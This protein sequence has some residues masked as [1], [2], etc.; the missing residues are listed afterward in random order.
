MEPET[1]APSVHRLRGYVLALTA[2]AVAASGTLV[3]LGYDEGNIWV[4]IA[5][6]ITAAIADR[7]SVRV[8]DALELSISPVLTLFAAVLF[9]PLAGG[10]V[11]AAHSSHSVSPDGRSTGRSQK[12]IGG[13]SCEP[14]LPQSGGGCCRC[15]FCGG[16][17]EGAPPPL[18]RGLGTSEPPPEP[19]EPPLIP[20]PPMTANLVTALVMLP[21]ELVMATV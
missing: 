20:T 11:G 6:C 1:P 4:L 18:S 10:L 7:A 14:R 17:A 5:I 12:G 9:G 2:T 16:E 15:P 8:S 19:P 3:V 13:P 21:K